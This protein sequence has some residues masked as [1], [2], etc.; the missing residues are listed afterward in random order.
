MARNPY[1]RDH[2]GQQ[3][4]IEDLTIE[5]IKS[6]GRD[7]VYIPRTLVNKDELFGEDVI[8]KFD[9]G[10]TLEMYIQSIDGFEGEGDILTKFGIEIRDRVTLVVSR[11]RFE[12]TV[13]IHE[14]STRPKE[15]D[16]IY[17]PLSKSLF[18]INFVEHEN[19]FYQVGKLYTYILSCELFTY[20]QE[21]IDTGFSDIDTVED[22]VKKFAIEFDMGTR[23]STGETYNFFEGET[24]F[25]GTDLDSATA[26]AVVTDWNSTAT[27]L[28]VTNVVG[29]ISTTAG[30]KLKG[31]VSGAEY[32]ITSSETTTL[33][34]PNDPQDNESRGDNEEIELL[35]DQD[36]IFD[37]TENDPFSEGDY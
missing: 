23:T 19:P 25:Q 33:V 11:K 3:D 24:V 32:E 6:M 22:E 28:T 8:S 4:V 14:G 21:E 18:E 34:I 7:M 35:R 12:Q 5:T 9:D 10:Y 15:G 31:A 30:Q 17:F 20:N 26:T 16:L 27:K 36:E 2:S 29:T 1:F 13:G 37:F